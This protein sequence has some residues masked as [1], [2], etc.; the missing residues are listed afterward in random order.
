MALDRLVGNMHQHLITNHLI[1]PLNHNLINS[2][3]QK[4]YMWWIETIKT[5]FDGELPQKVLNELKIGVVL[6]IDQKDKK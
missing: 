6:I 5:L 2:G 1:K 4:L 3:N